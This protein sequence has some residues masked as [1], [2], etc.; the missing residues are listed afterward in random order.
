MTAS[1]GV[2]LPNQV[3]DVD[4]RIIA[5][6][7]IAAEQAGFAALATVGRI[8]YPGVMD[9]VALAAA[10]GATSRI[11]LVSGVVVGTA[12]P[13]VL[14]AKE[15]AA[16]DGVS[17]GRLTLGLGIGNR[18]DDFTVPEHGFRGL[19]ARMDAA[20]HTYRSVWRGDPVGGGPN[21][22]VPSGTRALPLMFG[23]FAP[24][25]FV[26]MA[27]WGVGYIAPSAHAQYAEAGFNAARAAWH[28]EGRDGE[29][30]LTALAYFVLGD[31][32]EGRRDVYDY[33]SVLGEDLAKSVTD[34]VLTT[35][36][37]IRRAIADCSDLGADQVILNPTRSDL[38]EVHRLADVI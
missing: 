14:F 27:R 11:E 17:G 3:R 36:D 7:A 4:P 20:L 9:T 38:S 33:Y 21:P 25:A 18:P 1:I 31:A 24:A 15:A 16:I 13:A 22:A 26:R 8:A 6:W 35:P 2:G 10:A 28:A 37:E 19:G 32:D 29:P 30:R 12:W 23:G 5:P 34:Q